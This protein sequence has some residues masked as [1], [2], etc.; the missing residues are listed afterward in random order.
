[1]DNNDVPCVDLLFVRLLFTLMIN[2]CCL[3][4]NTA[5]SHISK[6]STE[7]QQCFFLLCV[8]FGYFP[9]VQID[10]FW[11]LHVSTS[12]W[13]EN[14]LLLLMM[15]PNRASVKAALA[16]SV[17][18][19]HKY[20]A[21]MLMAVKVELCLEALRVIFRFICSTGDESNR[22]IRASLC[23]RR[24]LL[25]LSRVGSDKHCSH[26]LHVGSNSVQANCLLCVP[27]RVSL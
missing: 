1:M 9:S 27:I 21:D 17:T 24:P 23:E 13:R 12:S 20:L 15:M 3:T 2:A 11:I 14:N 4:V 10:S 8:F 6:P 22:H 5:Y 16:A 7:Q 25:I 26:R 18:C 19:E